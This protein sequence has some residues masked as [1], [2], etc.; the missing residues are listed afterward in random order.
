M[1]LCNLNETHLWCEIQEVGGAMWQWVKG[2]GQRDARKLIKV[3]EMSAFALG[4]KRF[5]RSFSQPLWA[6]DV[7]ECQL[8]C[9]WWEKTAS[10]ERVWQL[11]KNIVRNA[12][13]F[14]E[15]ITTANSKWNEP[16]E[17]QFAIKSWTPIR[18]LSMLFWG[19]GLKRTRKETICHPLCDTLF[20][21]Y[22]NTYM[23]RR[24]GVIFRDSL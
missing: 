6:D 9:L 5:N 13:T 21:T 11:H 1:L 10:R 16:C 22:V 7:T 20:I 24:R 2:G 3:A 15:L 23:F 19:S 8:L 17:I 18:I 14:W 4:L 12:A